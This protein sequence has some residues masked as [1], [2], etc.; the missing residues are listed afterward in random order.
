MQKGVCR[1]KINIVGQGVKITDHLENMIKGRLD[2]FHRY[3]DDRTTAEVKLQPVQEQLKVEITLNIDRHYYRAE[4]VAPDALSAMQI[5]VD[6]MEGQIRKHKSR[7][8]RQ[9][10][11]FGYMKQYLTEEVYESDIQNEEQS[12]IS[13]RKSFQ[14]LPMDADEATLQMEMLGHDFFAF[15]NA[16]TGMVNLVYKRR[17][18]ADYGWIEF[19]Y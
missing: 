17:D 8:K 11:Q 18:D 16:E 14:I 13:R 1:M 6:I 5:A 9:R 3:F 7:M 2:K 12:S 10:K 15:L 4:A 19:E